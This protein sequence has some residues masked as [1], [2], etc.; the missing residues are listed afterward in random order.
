MKKKYFLRLRKKIASVHLQL[1][2]IM[3]QSNTSENSALGKVRG[4]VSWSARE[5]TSVKRH[6][7]KKERRWLIRIHQTHIWNAEQARREGEHPLSLSFCISATWLTLILPMT[8]FI[9]PLSPKSGI[10]HFMYDYNEMQSYFL[11]FKIKV[12]HST[13]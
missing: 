4:M 2:T 13:V 3:S 11:F 5:G 10:F 1:S 12:W 8:P 9:L 6:Y 7:C